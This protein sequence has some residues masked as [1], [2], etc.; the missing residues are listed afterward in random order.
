MGKETTEKVSEAKGKRIVVAKGVA[1]RRALRLERPGAA[2]PAVTGIVT[3]T[4]QPGGFLLPDVP[5]RA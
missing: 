2:T 1:D 4:L 5:P 3:P